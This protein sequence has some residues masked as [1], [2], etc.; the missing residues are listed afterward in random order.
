MPSLSNRVTPA[1]MRILGTGTYLPRHR[2][3]SAEI[4]H[5]FG[6]ADG[7][8]E[9]RYGLAVRHVA[10][11]GESSSM[12]AAEAAAQALRA[13]RMKASDLDLI[14]GACG[15]ME[16]AIPSTATLVQARLGLGKSGVPSYDVNATCLS[17][18]QALDLAALRI[19]AGRARRVLV[20]SADI[21][22]VGLDWAEPDTAAIFGDG[23]A[24]VVLG[25]DDRE[26]VLASR[27][28]TYSEGQAACVLEGGGTRYGGA[29]DP[30]LLGRTN[31]FHMDGQTAFRISARY[32]P[33]FL[34]ALM[35]EAGIG[36]RDLACIVPHQ[37][38]GPA[39]DHGLARLGV[40]LEKVIRTFGSLGNQIATS[41][42]TALHHAITSGRLK[43]GD[44]AMLVGT[45]AGVSLGG[46][47]VRY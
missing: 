40:P 4:D 42:P 8:T 43:R 17:F 16:Q 3:T 19:A 34:K 15:V 14:L 1:A 13:A 41:I 37:A 11:Q 18:V 12:M 33:R 5:R 23:A 30:E 47:V 39:L 6:W 38:S 24:A 7:T 32:L 45:S 26:G 35:A 10:G 28:E 25:A 46:M 31:V 21:A 2:L 27:F 22:S 9:A 29:R 44:L 20:F 36:Y